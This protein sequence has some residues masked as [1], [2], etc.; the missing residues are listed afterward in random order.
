MQL[1]SHFI[2]FVLPLD[3]NQSF[4]SSHC[5]FSAFTAIHLLHKLD[6]ALL[7]YSGWKSFI[8]NRHAFSNLPT[9]KSQSLCC[10]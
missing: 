6:I 4:F 7:S 8:T 10:H 1:L 3:Y 2:F 5:S 9:S